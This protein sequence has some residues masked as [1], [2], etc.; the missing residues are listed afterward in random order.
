MV[1]HFCANTVI[2]KALFDILVDVTSGNVSTSKVQFMMD[3]VSK[4]VI[5]SQAES[6]R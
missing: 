5:A 6:N 1:A 2:C 4:L 3:T